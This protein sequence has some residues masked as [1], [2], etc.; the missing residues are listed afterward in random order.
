MVL[1]ATINSEKSFKRMLN[2]VYGQNDESNQI[3]NSDKTFKVSIMRKSYR[4]LPLKLR[5]KHEKSNCF[6]E[7]FIYLLR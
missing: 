2:S 4:T 3:D 1:L 7:Y 6:S 5:K